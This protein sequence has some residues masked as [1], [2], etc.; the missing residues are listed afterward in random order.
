M[1]LMAV[2]PQRRG[3]A[4]RPAQ[5]H[6]GGGRGAARRPRAAEGGPRLDARST[7]SRRPK[8][9]WR[10]SSTS[11]RSCRR[12][13]GVIRR[14][15]F[16]SASSSTSR[17]DP[18][19]SRDGVDWRLAVNEGPTGSRARGAGLGCPA[20]RQPGAAAGVCQLR[21]PPVPDRPQQA[22]Y[23]ALVLDGDLRQP[24]EGPSALPPRPRGQRLT[25]I[26]RLQRN[27][28]M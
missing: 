17:C 28:S 16:C 12:W 27:P 14:P 6:T 21:V 5:H 1:D 8:R 26:P 3:V 25:E 11:G 7:T 13:C 20:R 24:D 15:Q 23:R 22:Q 10:H 4:A 18:T 9:S 2:R 19:A